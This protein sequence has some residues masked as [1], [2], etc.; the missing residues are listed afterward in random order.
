M[1]NQLH[2][3]TQVKTTL[4]T[5]WNQPVQQMDFKAN[6]EDHTKLMPW[7]CFNKHEYFYIKIIVHLLTVHSLCMS[8]KLTAIIYTNTTWNMTWSVSKDFVYKMMLGAMEGW[9]HM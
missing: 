6:W 9:M 5:K 4:W 8:K 2:F 7:Q 1:Q 3:N